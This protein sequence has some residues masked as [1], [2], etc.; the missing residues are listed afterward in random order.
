MVANQYQSNI[1]SNL[2][3]FHIAEE[4]SKEKKQ[5]LPNLGKIICEHN[6]ENQIGICLLH[7]H[8]NLT[9]NEMLVRTFTDNSFEIEPKSNFSS[10]SL[11]YMWA[12]SE[13]KTENKNALYPIEFI[14]K[15]SVTN[16]FESTIS[17]FHVKEDFLHSI[18]NY[19]T[20]LKLT[21]IFGISL[22]PHG[23]FEL[24]KNETL[25]ENDVE[26]ERKLRISVVPS[27]SIEKAKTAQTLWIFNQYGESTKKIDCTVHCGLHCS[28]HCG[29]HCGIHD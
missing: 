22:I 4:I 24:N 17:E 26:G 21:N 8:F 19:L 14:E 10:R 15:N 2:L 28:I 16:S 23:L 13:T 20:D 25:I 12:F 7:K 27:K 11:P 9:P 6:L 29:I 1:Y 3:D 18:K 5:Y